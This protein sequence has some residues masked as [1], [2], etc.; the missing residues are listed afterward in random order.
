MGAKQ[1]DMNGILRIAIRRRIFR[2][3]S[4]QDLIEYALMAGFVTVA[5]AAIM[6]DLSSSINIVFSTVNSMM[7]PAASS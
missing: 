3:L 2:E 4:G 5:A 6:P 7:I 1:S